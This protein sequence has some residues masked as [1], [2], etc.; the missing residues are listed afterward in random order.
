MQHKFWVGAKAIR[1]TASTCKKNALTLEGKEAL[2][3]YYNPEISAL[4]YKLRICLKFLLSLC[5]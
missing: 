4:Y 2:L 3:N 1:N 5:V